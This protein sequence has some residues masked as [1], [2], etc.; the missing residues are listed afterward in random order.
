MD[1]FDED[2]NVRQ[3]KDSSD[4]RRLEDGKD[5]IPAQHYP[6]P[7]RVSVTYVSRPA[8]HQTEEFRGEIATVVQS[9]SH[10]NRD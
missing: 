6:V 1:V 10:F 8:K 2:S 9:E 3:S 5:A 4:V 7:V